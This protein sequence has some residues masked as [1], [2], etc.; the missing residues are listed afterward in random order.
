MN[1]SNI[2]KIVNKEISNWDP[3]NLLKMGAPK[4]EYDIEVK[5]I[6]FKIQNDTNIDIIANII[7]DVLIEMFGEDTFNDTN[8]FKSE[9]NSVAKRIF[10][11]LY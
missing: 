5:M 11:Q 9:C 2:L 6:T 7:Y 8:S 4:D 10:S 1:R 3:I